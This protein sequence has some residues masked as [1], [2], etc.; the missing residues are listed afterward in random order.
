M[1]HLSSPRKNVPWLESLKA[2]LTLCLPERAVLFC[3]PGSL[4]A[5]L[6]TWTTFPLREKRHSGYGCFRTRHTSQMYCILVS[7]L[8]RSLFF[9]VYKIY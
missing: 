9:P 1:S 5:P 8:G 2:F 4:V 7:I 6:N 3:P